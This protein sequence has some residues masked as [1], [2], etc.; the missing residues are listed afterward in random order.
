MGVER[1]RKDGLTILIFR[2]T[3]NLEPQASSKCTTPSC[4]YSETRSCSDGTELFAAFNGFAKASDSVAAELTF[5]Q[6]PAPAR[7]LDMAM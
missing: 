2:R 5:A 4:K 6:Q 3:C 1:S 7:E